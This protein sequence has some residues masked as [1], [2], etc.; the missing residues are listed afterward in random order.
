MTKP[1]GPKIPK[2]KSEAEEAAWWDANEDYIVERLK[3]HGRVVGP[4]KIKQVDP[5]TKAISLRLP[6]EDLQQ[7]QA[8]AKQKGIGYQ[9]VLKEAIR[10]GL[11]K[12]G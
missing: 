3:R 5:P 8:I 6:L 12:T 11:R 9:T 1:S 2:F 10:K 4:L 7:A